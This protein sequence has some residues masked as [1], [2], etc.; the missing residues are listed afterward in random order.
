MVGNCVREI[1][2]QP[3]IHVI[4]AKVSGVREVKVSPFW[5]P[6]TNFCRRTV[7]GGYRGEERNCQVHVTWQ[8]MTINLCLLPTVDIIVCCC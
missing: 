3:L 7:I 8:L 1:V 2:L 5:K 6:V 4:M